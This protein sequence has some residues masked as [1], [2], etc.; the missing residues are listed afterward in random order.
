ME[1]SNPQGT[2]KI[3]KSLH[4]V[5]EVPGHGWLDEKETRFFLFKLVTKLASPVQIKEAYYE[6]KMQ[7]APSQP[8]EV[9]ISFHYTLLL[10]SSCLF[11]Y[12]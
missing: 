6:I 3:V 11:R 4:I 12:N 10:F 5:F 9:S 8:K 7:M 1:G 2:M